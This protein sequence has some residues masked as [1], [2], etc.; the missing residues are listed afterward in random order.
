M[1]VHIYRFTYENSPMQI[2]VYK[3]RRTR[4]PPP[5]IRHDLPSYSDQKNLSTS[6]LEY[7]AVSSISPNDM[8]SPA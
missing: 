4:R 2:Y 8:I 1:K 3:R 7:S 6:S 5:H